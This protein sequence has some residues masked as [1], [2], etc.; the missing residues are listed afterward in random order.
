MGLRK[1]RTK[2]VCISAVGLLLLILLGGWGS[3]GHRIINSE[4]VVD[5]PASMQFFIR[6]AGFLRDHASDADNRK[7]QDSQK[8]YILQ[9]GPRHFIDME[10][11][12]E[13]ASKSIPEDFSAVISEYDSATVFDIGIVPWAA[14]WTLDSLTAQLKRGDTLDALK[15]AADLGHYVG[16]AHQPL[17]CTQDY[18]GRSSLSGS[19]GIHSRYETTMITRHQNEIAFQQDT[20]QYISDP[21]DFMFSIVYES[22]AY[23]DSI[24]AADVY[25]RQVTGWSGSGSIPTAYTD[26]LWVRTQSFT[27]LQFQRAGVRYADLLYTAWVNSL[28]TATTAVS[29]PIASSTQPAGFWLGQNY[30]NPFNPTTTISYRVPREAHVS[31]SVYSL[32]GKLVATLESRVLQA[33]EHRSIFDGSGLSS[34]MYVYRLRI[35][36]PN[37]T[38]SSSR[39]LLLLK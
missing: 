26:T 22:N 16:D 37:G 19:Y 4:V 34:G 32:Q 1:R 20:V 18:N 38:F 17:H 14:V 36:S 3:T 11:F 15:S 29:A 8:P 39:K 35:S 21:I 5:L 6:N 31:L 33:G 28:D 12:S 13:F 9:E 10:R 23:V 7:N 25:A 2:S 24:Y 30:P 27:K